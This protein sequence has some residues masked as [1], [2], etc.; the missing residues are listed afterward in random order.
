MS[1]LV[2][3]TEKICPYWLTQLS[4]IDFYSILTLNFNRTERNI[5]LYFL[6]LNLSN[7]TGLVLFFIPF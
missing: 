5:K 7:N 6:V 3:N 1:K 2:V 4:C